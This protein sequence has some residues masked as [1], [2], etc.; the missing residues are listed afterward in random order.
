M[1]KGFPLFLHFP[2]R[3]LSWPGIF[4]Y[5]SEPETQRPKPIT[6]SAILAVRHI[7]CIIKDTLKLYGPLGRYSFRRF[8]IINYLSLKRPGKQIQE[9]HTRLERIYS[10]GDAL[11]Y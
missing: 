6:I 2:G 9:L 10:F 7:C 3:H 1:E 4:F 8:H 5:P 11:P